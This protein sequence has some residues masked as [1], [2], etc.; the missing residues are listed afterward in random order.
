MEQEQKQ[1]TKDENKVQKQLLKENK[2][3]LEEERKNYMLEMKGKINKIQKQ[4]KYEKL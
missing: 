4:I 3:K 2:K 1:K